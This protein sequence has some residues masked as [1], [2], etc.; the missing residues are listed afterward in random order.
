M[1]APDQPISADKAPATPDD[2]DRTR[3]NDSIQHDTA[4]EAS[5]GS[6]TST[7][8][9]YVNVSGYRFVDLEHLPELQ[10]RML[11][12]FKQIGVKGTVLIAE[13]GIN[14]ALVGT[15]EQILT[16]RQW[17]DQDSRFKAIWLK[18]SYSDI[19]PFSKLKIRIRPEIITFQSDTQDNVSPLDTPAPNILPKQLKDWLDSNKQ[20]TLLDTRN[21]YEIES[22]TFEQAVELDMKTFKH[23]G[24]A[25]EEA[26][27][28]GKLNKDE[29]IVTFCTGGVRCE[30]AAPYLLQHGFK[31]VYQVEGGIL[32]YFEECGGEHWQGDCFV[33]D[34]RVE[35]NPDLEPTGADICRKCHR[36]VPKYGSCDCKPIH[37]TPGR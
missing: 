20:F 6:S 2:I 7:Q 15:A 34:D 17:L 33:F 3:Q 4:A 24:K 29:P 37:G 31:E 30:K 21:D 8:G 14:I 32:N 26:V 11:T 36:A 12:D 18:E 19:A 35:I 23:F 27:A 1:P 13:E 25:V 9:P 5:Q 10:A 28:A 22:G 16:I